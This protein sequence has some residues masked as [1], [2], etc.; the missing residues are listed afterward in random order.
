MLQTFPVSGQL[1]RFV[2][3]HGQMGTEFRIVMFDEDSLHASTAAKKA[4]DRVD[5]LNHILSDY[6]PESELNALSAS[7]GKD[8]LVKVS[9]DLWKVLYKAK[10]IS[11]LSDG[12]FDVTV[13]QMVRLWR[14]A[15]QKEEFPSEDRLNEARESTGYTFIEFNEDQQ[16]VKLTQDGMRL[17][18]GGIAK[19]ICRP[20][21]I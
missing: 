20:R 9:Q 4:F 12:A 18:L 13:G 19:G 7:A 11:Q 1:S 8:S 16:A 10:E 14:R 17:D 2:F 5:E 6:D 15:R 21:S 3:S